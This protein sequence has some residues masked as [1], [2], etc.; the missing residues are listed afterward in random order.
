VLEG[1][2]VIQPGTQTARRN[3]N[4][5]ICSAAVAFRRRPRDGDKR[6]A[7]P[8]RVI[9]RSARWHLGSDG[10]VVF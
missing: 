8:R 1:N 3:G 5:S 2:E 6:S 9:T 10:L 4:A 7:K